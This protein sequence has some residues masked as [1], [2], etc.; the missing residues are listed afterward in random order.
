MGQFLNLTGQRFGALVAKEYLGFWRG[1]SWWRCLCDCGVSK[2]FTRSNLR[3]KSRPAGSCGCRRVSKCGKPVGQ[4]GL[5]N[6]PTYH[7]WGH[8]INRCTNPKNSGW[9]NYG[10]RGITVCERWLSVQNFIADMGERPPGTTIDRINNDLGYSPDNC[11]WASP[12]EQ[13][14]NSRRNRWLTFK[15]KTQCLQDWARELGINRTTLSHRLKKH[16]VELALAG[17]GYERPGCGEW[18][19]PGCVGCKETWTT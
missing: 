15:G 16:S 8:M 17:D 10:G 3:S 6:H 2:V 12:R 5:T 19:R 18:C 13:S 9:K 7:I 14:R 11:R 1:N 4:H